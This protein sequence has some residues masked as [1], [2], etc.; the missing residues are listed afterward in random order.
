MNPCVCCSLCRVKWCVPLPPFLT[1]FV[2]HL[3]SSLSSPL[4]FQAKWTIENE[5]FGDTELTDIPAFAHNR[6]GIRHELAYKLCVCWVVAMTY[7]SEV[8][9][10][11]PEGDPN[12]LLQN[13]FLL[14]NRLNRAFV[15]A[16]GVKHGSIAALMRF[17]WHTEG[18]CSVH[19]KNDT[20]AAYE[21]WVRKLGDLTMPDLE[22]CLDELKTIFG[23]DKAVALQKFWDDNAR[24]RGIVFDQV[25]C[26]VP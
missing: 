13:T 21:K 18:F 19:Q 6:F 16:L 22:G 4:R 11:D 17:V 24:E 25:A 7:V 3:D 9:M 2:S 15:I 23:G 20:I 14:R 10:H 5:I 1:S 12:L 26:C 8:R